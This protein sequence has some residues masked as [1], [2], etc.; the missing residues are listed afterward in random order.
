[1]TGKDD[2]VGG[3]F[4][5]IGAKNNQFRE[6]SAQSSA[7]DAQDRWPLF[8]SLA[9]DARTPPPRL[10]PSE[11]QQW[12][13]QA[14]PAVAPPAPAPIAPAKSGFASQLAK[15]L[16]RLTHRTKPGASPASVFANDS[17]GISS[18]GPLP[19][20]TRAT[21][22]KAHAAPV[23][24]PPVAPVAPAASLSASHPPHAA[25]GA[26]PPAAPIMP[27]PPAAKPH[28]PLF[29]SAPEQSASPK[30]FGA[31]KPSGS[32]LFGKAPPAES[33]PERPASQHANPLPGN[34]PPPAPASG[35]MFGRQRKAAP[36]P[37]T[38][39][40][41]ATGALFGKPAPAPESAGLFGK[42]AANNAQSPAPSVAQ[43]VAPSAAPKAAQNA[44]PKTAA[45][46]TPAKGLFPHGNAPATPEP[47]AKPAG[48]LFAKATPVAPAKGRGSLLKSRKP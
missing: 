22:A 46:R 17:A 2:D 24:T 28:K 36:A 11:K 4:K 47:P 42:R 35:G 30:L 26:L 27:S 10:A 9:I 18:G 12:L 41:P 44:A 19:P 1:M 29:A 25:I 48:K 14:A 21:Q 45:S 20:A 16:R 13:K 8:K 5:A 6:F 39:A 37:L 33:K 31:A 7:K 43:S 15:G 23:A 32:G 38:P 3:L 34:P 40:A